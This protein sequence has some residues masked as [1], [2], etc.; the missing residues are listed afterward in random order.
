MY[1]KR[2][3]KAIGELE[4]R[5]RSELTFVPSVLNNQKKLGKDHVQR[6]I[7]NADHVSYSI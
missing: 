2:T 3:S 6:L 1:T 5:E 7:E 4:A